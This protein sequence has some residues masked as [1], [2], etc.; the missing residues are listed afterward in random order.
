VVDVSAEEV[1]EALV[2]VELTVDEA[3]KNSEV[4][5]V[6]STT[7]I[8]TAIAMTAITVFCRDKSFEKTTTLPR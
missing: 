6:D 3:K 5:P 8:T 1:D 7:T 4:S 2:V